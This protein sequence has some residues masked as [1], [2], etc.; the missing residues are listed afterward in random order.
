MTSADRTLRHFLLPIAAVLLLAAWM[1]ATHE[2]LGLG[3]LPDRPVVGYRARSVSVLYALHGALTWFLSCDV[4][5]YGPVIRFRA[6]A[7][8]LCGVG[9]VFLDVA[10]GMPAYWVL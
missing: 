1:A 7:T 4:R 8:M 9:L 3:D 10:V 6:V 5:R 2:W